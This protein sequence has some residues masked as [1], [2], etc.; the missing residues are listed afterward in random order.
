[1]DVI[2]TNEKQFITINEL[3]NLLND[4]GK[5]DIYSI[6]F[7]TGSSEIK[8]ESKIEVEML[9]IFLKSQPELKIAI[10]GHTDNIGSHSYN[11]KLSEDRAK[12]L[13]NM[14][15]ESFGVDASRISAIGFGESKPIATNKT[16]E[17]RTLNRRVEI[18]K[19]E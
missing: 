9:A 8:Q 12:S 3:S 19:I 16:E 17:G 6:V 2:E 15:V 1:M 13:K 14:I 5:V 11:Q 4:K 10:G 18:I 7:E